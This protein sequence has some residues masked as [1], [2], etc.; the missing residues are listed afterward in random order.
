MNITKNTILKKMSK[1]SLI[2]NS[3]GYLL[4]ES[5]ISTIKTQAKISDVKLT[6]FG[7]FSS[8]KTPQRMGRNPKTQ[9]SYI[10]QESIKLNFRPSMKIKEKIN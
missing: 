1:E 10:I 5:F 7:T 4:L 9:V 6:G 8:K 2:S 3:D